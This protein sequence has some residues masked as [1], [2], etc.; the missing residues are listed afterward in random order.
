M[1]NTDLNDEFM[2]ILE[3]NMPILL[4]I[5]KAYTNLRQDREDLIAE[6]ILQMWKSYNSF[7][8]DSKVSTWVYRVALNTSMNY[9][10]KQ[11]T[12][13]LASLLNETGD[14]DI[15]SW[16][17]IEQE[18]SS[19]IDLLYRSIDDLNT[20]DKAIIL[21]YLDK[22]SHE[23]ISEIT[24]ISKTNVGTRIGRIKDKLKKIITSNN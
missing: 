21:L 3:K 10:R 16:L 5:S 14:K 4:K 2:D 17:I 1:T 23:E 8:K 22:N 18:D 13:P 19:E 7:R 20:I 9:K 12:N 6:I 11:K 24:G 15:F